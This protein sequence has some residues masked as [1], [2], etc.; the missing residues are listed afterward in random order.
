M[1]TNEYLHIINPE[2][3]KATMDELQSLKLKIE[4]SV[5]ARSE[6]YTNKAELM[7]K[8][9]ELETAIKLTEAEAFMNTEFVGKD[10]FGT[11]D[12]RR[13]TLNNEAN[14]NTYRRMASKMERMELGAVMADLAVIEV[15]FSKADNEWQAAIEQLAAVKARAAIQSK[16]LSMVGKSA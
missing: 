1:N 11:I 12:E 15:N 6:A 10:Q 16:L 8:K 7:K 5:Q 14:R 3:I 4:Q 2:M 13:I 9:T